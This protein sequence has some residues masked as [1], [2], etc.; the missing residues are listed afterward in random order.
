MDKLKFS[1]HFECQNALL[2]SSSEEMLNIKKL[3][4]FVKKK[5]FNIMYTYC[6]KKQFL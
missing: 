3:T 1:S 6:L 5:Y 4:G 2:F